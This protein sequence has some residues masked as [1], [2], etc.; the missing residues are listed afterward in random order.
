MNLLTTDRVFSSRMGSRWTGESFQNRVREPCLLLE[1]WLWVSLGRKECIAKE[2]Q[3]ARRDVIMAPA[4]VSLCR[5]HVLSRTSLTNAATSGERLAFRACGQAHKSSWSRRSES[6]RWKRQPCHR[7]LVHSIRC[8]GRNWRWG[9]PSIRSVHQSIRPQPDD[10]WDTNPRA[11]C[12][13]RCSS[14][15]RPSPLRSGPR[16]QSFLES[17]LWKAVDLLIS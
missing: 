16:T 10:P 17:G 5:P 15:A 4:R 13:A 2:P 11:E 3:H 7:S 8:A 9:C 12:R 14:P 1:P 6:H